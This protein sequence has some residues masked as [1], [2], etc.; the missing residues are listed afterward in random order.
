MIGYFNITG[1]LRSKHSLKFVTRYKNTVTRTVFNIT[2]FMRTK[3]KY[4][5]GS[6]ITPLRAIQ[7]HD[8]FLNFIFEQTI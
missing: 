4:R 5:K 7:P 3:I 8:L 6:Q 2:N 1:L